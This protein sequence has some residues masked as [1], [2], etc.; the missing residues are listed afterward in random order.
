MVTLCQTCMPD[1]KLQDKT[2][3]LQ[4][5]DQSMSV[6][7]PCPSLQIV[8]NANFTF[9]G[10]LGFFYLKITKINNKLLFSISVMCEFLDHLPKSRSQSETN[11]FISSSVGIFKSLFTKNNSTTAWWCSLSL[12]HS[13]C[14]PSFYWKLLWLQQKFILPLY[15]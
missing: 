12:V 1:F 9:W 15:Q 3:E 10:F 7:C 13:Q 8:V 5:Q 11:L 14:C 2:V 6:L 4:D